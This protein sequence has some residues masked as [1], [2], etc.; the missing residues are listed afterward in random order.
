MITWLSENW[1]WI[2][3]AWILIIP[4]LILWLNSRRKAHKKTGKFD[5]YAEEYDDEVGSTNISY[6]KKSKLDYHLSA[7]QPEWHE[8]L[9]EELR[10]LPFGKIIFN[11]PDVMKVGVKNR[12]ETR[13]TRDADINLLTSLKGH[14]IPKIEEL[15]ISELMKVRLSGSDF[16]IIHHNEEE[17]VIEEA[18]FTEWAWD[19]TPRRS[20]KKA[21]HLHVTLRI[22]L[23]YGVE[24][25]DHP[26]LDRDIVVKVNPAYTVKIFIVSY[27]KWIVTALILPLIGLVWKLL[28][29]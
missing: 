5:I 23:P 24:K 18:G 27:W 12:I 22:R 8:L 11:P 14:G 3:S 7:D 4:I 16:N 6:R 13:I 19:A 28:T 26:V 15:R 17:Q 9:K 20:G 2:V 1:W 10:R 25:K 29:K 21:L